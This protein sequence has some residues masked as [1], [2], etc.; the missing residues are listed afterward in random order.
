VTRPKYFY[1][2]HDVSTPRRFATYSTKYYYG[3]PAIT[4][5]NVINLSPSSS[6]Q[7]KVAHGEP[8]DEPFQNSNFYAAPLTS[9]LP[10]STHLVFSFSIYEMT[11]T[12]Y[13]H[14]TTA[15]FPSRPLTVGELDRDSQT[16][17][18]RHRPTATRD[19]SQTSK[20]ESTSFHPG[21]CGAP[22]SH[23]HPKPTDRKAKSRSARGRA[24]EP[25][26]QKHKNYRI[27]RTETT[28]TTTRP[29]RGAH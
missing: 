21:G 29:H 27:R 1:S 19:Q 22:R 14:E 3:A 6:H 8:V 28:T 16:Q 13:G 23:P 5:G 7:P 18:S 17:L 26:P 20:P 11:V 15:V 2:L 10:P 12:D 24:T 4:G 25:T 9:H